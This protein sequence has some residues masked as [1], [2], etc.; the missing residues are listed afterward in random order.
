MVDCRLEERQDGV[1]KRS[2]NGERLCGSP[3]GSTAKLL[4]VFYAKMA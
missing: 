4:T 1:E 3:G 2:D